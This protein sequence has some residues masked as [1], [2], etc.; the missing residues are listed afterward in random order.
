MGEKPDYNELLDYTRQLEQKGCEPGGYAET[1]S[2]RRHQGENQVS[3][4]YLTRDQDSHECHHR[5][6]APSG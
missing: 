5:F 4:Q 6:F 1:V 3:I 2:V